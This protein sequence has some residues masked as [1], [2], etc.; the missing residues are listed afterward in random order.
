[1][2]NL[3]LLNVTLK[4]AYGL[5]SIR[6]ALSSP[7]TNKLWTILILLITKAPGR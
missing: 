1:M 4:Q 3:Q 5:L 7:G 2:T 6:Q